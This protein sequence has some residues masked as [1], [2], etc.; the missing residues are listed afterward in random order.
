MPR[1]IWH[2]KYF[3]SNHRQGSLLR[4]GV[5]Q[6]KATDKREPRSQEVREGPRGREGGRGGRGSAVFPTAQ[7]AEAGASQ[8]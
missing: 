6:G 8:L 5:L 2:V 7:E 4:L 1:D 3:T